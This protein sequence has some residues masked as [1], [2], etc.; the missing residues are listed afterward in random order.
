M[1]CVKLGGGERKGC[2]PP[3]NKKH[4]L[5]QVCALTLSSA[6]LSWDHPPSNSSFLFKKALVRVT[7]LNGDGQKV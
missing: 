4:L 2:L 1:G 5:C 6:L 3:R 7:F